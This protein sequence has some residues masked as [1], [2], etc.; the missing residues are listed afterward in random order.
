MILMHANWKSIFIDRTERVKAAG[1]RETFSDTE[2]LV[3]C[4]EFVQQVRGWE[5][6]RR[7]LSTVKFAICE[8]YYCQGR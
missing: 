3:V 6:G 4:F 7:H 2:R 1:R 5:G 8:V